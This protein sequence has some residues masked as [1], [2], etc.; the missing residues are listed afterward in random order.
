MIAYPSLIDRSWPCPN[1]ADGCMIANEGAY[2]PPPRSAIRWEIKH[3]LKA[4]VYTGRHVTRPM[5]RFKP[6]P[7]PQFP[8][9]D[10]AN[11]PIP[12]QSVIM[13]PMQ[14]ERRPLDECLGNCRG[15]LF[16]SSAGD[17]KSTLNHI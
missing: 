11:I 2:C 16:R 1:P 15:G 5:D 3:P 17:Y 6:A 12:S 14:L 13:W 7:M 9:G 4:P 8:A 10:I